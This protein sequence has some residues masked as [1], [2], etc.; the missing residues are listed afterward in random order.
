MRIL[1][2]GARGMLGRD[3]CS[4]LSARHRVT[5]VDRSEADITDLDAVRALVGNVRPDLVLHAAAFTDVDGAESRSEEARRVNTTG[6]WHLAMAAKEVRAGIAYVST[7]YVF[8]GA[9]G[10]VYAEGDRPNPIN[11]YGETKLGGE[12]AVISLISGSY[13]IRTSWLFAPH[14]KNFVNTILRLARERGH[15]EVVTD[16][17]GT[18]TYTLDLAH[19]INAILASGVPGVYHVANDGPCS[20]FQFAGE[21]LRQTGTQ[22]ALLPTTSDQ[23]RR[24]ARRPAYSALSTERLTRRVGHWMRSWQAALAECLARRR[25]APQEVPPCLAEVTGEVH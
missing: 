18:P 4:V 14:G 13:I 15:L 25:C 6:A 8:D 9:K 7:D 19:A 10:T 12:H 17:V 16:Q 22:A 23:F 5:G 1:V 2:T 20:W 3:L 21:I 11:V 24:P